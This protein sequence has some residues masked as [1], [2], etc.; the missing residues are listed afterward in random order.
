MLKQ[1]ISHILLIEDNL[2]NARLIVDMLSERKKPGFTVKT[3]GTL[4]EG[5]ERI[6]K[7]GIDVILLDLNLP[8]SQGIETLSTLMSLGQ[9]IPIIVTS[10]LEDE[11]IALEALTRGAS[12]YLLKGHIDVQILTRSIRYALERKR[13]EDEILKAKEQ[14]EKAFEKENTGAA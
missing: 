2:F 12:D 14:L 5:I 13:K 10:A 11:S 8:D 6:S 4:A 1:K 3:A 7:G 9:S